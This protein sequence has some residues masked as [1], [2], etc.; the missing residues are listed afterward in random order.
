MLS[1]C[2]SFLEELGE[3]LSPCCCQPLEVTVTI[4]R[5]AS[6]PPPQVCSVGSLNILLFWPLPPP[7]LSLTDTLPP[8]YKTWAH[9]GSKIISSSRF[10]SV[11]VFNS[12]L[13][14]SPLMV[15]CGVHRSPPTSFLL[16]GFSCH[17]VKVNR[18]KKREDKRQEKERLKPDSESSLRCSSVSKAHHIY[19]VLLKDFIACFWF[20]AV[21]RRI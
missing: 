9:L 14:I 20:S 19:A 17:V 11:P 7:P 6:L 4:L 21:F 16:P 8:V 3:I 10:L 1:G 12:L 5:Q 18:C 13:G 2:P 15:R